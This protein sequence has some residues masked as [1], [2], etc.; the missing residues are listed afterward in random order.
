MRPVTSG[1]GS[2]P[3]SRASSM[4]GQRSARIRKGPG[5]FAWTTGI[6]PEKSWSPGVFDPANTTT[7]QITASSTAAASTR[8]GWSVMQRPASSEGN[9]RKAA[10]AVA[11]SRSASS[12]RR[13]VRWRNGS[14]SSVSPTLPTTSN[15][16]SMMCSPN[17]SAARPATATSRRRAAAVASASMST[18]GSGSRTSRS[19]RM[20]AVAG[21]AVARRLLRRSTRPAR[22]T[23]RARS[24]SAR[25]TPS[26]SAF[27]CR[28]RASVSRF[29]SRPVG[30]RM[31]QPTQCSA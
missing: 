25:S 7:A 2:I 17:R 31:S 1:R 15:S 13:D 26:A 16:S 3:T 12:G 20:P 10:N 11:T 28:A 27:R 4:S 30:S 29:G 8:S 23:P 24:S 9:V 21:S 6:G 22:A 18:A 5:S 19:S 14:S